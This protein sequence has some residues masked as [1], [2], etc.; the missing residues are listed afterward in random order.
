MDRVFQ[1]NCS[2]RKNI[3]TEPGNDDPVYLAKMSPW[4][5]RTTWRTGPAAVKALTA[6]SDSDSDS[7]T[8]KSDI[9]GEGRLHGLKIDCETTIRGRN[10]RISAAKKWLTRYNYPSTAFSSDPSRPVAMTWHSNSNWKCLDMD[11]RDENGELVAK[12]NPR[13][14]GVR[15]MA[16]FE[17]IGTK[18]WDTS[19]VEEVLITGVTLYICMIYRISNIVPFVAAVVAR[20]GKD[21]KVTEQQIREEEERVLA[22]SANDPVTSQ[23]AK[24]EAPENFW[25]SV[26]RGTAQEVPADAKTA[27]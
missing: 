25:D 27:Q 12:F 17:M 5:M 22:T 10:I 4:T 16:T 6:D 14:L 23:D 8:T 2:W 9:I 7:K 20:P 19:A 21:Y 26:D 3:V 1:V 13:Y 18:A 15:K 11:L 24:F